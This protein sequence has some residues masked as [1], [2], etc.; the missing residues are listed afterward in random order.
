MSEK[1]LSSRIVHKHDSAEHWNLA[2]NFVPKQGELIV[3]DIDSQYS[4]ERIKIGDGK[5]NVNSL[6]FVDDALRTA[7]IGLINA[8]DDK[9]DAVSALVGDKAVSTQISSAIATKA[10]TNHTHSAYVNQNAFSNVKVGDVTVAADSVT[11]TITLVAGSNVTLTPDATNDKITIE[12]KDTVYTHPNSGVT[13]GTYKSV[14]VNAQ[15]HVTGGSNPTTLSGY[16]I[17]DAATKTELNALNS[18]VGDTAI[19]T[20]I[21]TAISAKADIDAGVYAVTATSNDGVA[22]AATVPGIPAL[23]SGASFIMI[24]GRV[25]NSVAPTIN[26]NGLGAKPIR[27]RL[28]NMSTSLQ[29]GYTVNWLTANVPFTLVYDGTTWIVEGLTKPVGADIY[30]PVA[31]AKADEEGNVITET[32]VTIASLRAMQPRI[33]TVDLPAARW[34]GTKSP[35]SQVVNI[36]GVT[37]NSQVDLTPS[38]EQLEIFYEKDLGFVT[39]NED[40]IVTVYA[41]GQKPENDYIIQVTITEVGV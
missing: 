29:N 21:N 5:T 40:G 27:R 18:L 41:I 4:Y 33:A 11:D 6:P 23:V 39:E 26:V 37:E 24:P 17:T 25:S 13:A 1:V 31:K 34:L 35:Y 8:V 14:T 36:E 32:Y 22:Y 2:K 3:Y 16:G 28:S 12:A 38:I 20:Q 7:L 9:V 10:D 19:S 15:G 30:G